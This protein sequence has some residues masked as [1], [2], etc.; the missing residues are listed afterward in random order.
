MLTNRKE[1]SHRTIEIKEDSRVKEVGFHH[2]AS[3][4]EHLELIECIKNKNH[5]LVDCQ[6]GFDSIVIGLAAQ[7]SIETGE[8]VYLN[9]FL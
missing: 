7:R 3:Y 2:G 6:K 4:I 5:P 8:P 1:Y 9:N